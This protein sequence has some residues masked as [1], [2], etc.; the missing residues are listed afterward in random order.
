M[1]RDEPADRADTAEVAFV[2]QDGWQSRLTSEGGDAV[3][4]G[5][6]GTHIWR[7]RRAL[8]PGDISLP[9]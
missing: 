4:D 9:R 7:S 5:I 3:F 1:A 2:V 6:G 8:R